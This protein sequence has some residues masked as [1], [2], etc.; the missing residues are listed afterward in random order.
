MAPG[1]GAGVVA[2]IKMGVTYIVAMDK[3][4]GENGVE[5]TGVAGTEGIADFVLRAASS[6][7]VLGQAM[8]MSVAAV[9]FDQEQ[10]LPE[11]AQRRRQL[12][13]GRRPRDRR[14]GKVRPGAAR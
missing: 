2:A 6:V 14:L 9:V 8:N 13:P 11:G 4:G 1:I 7:P 12:L 10:P 5:I 3:L